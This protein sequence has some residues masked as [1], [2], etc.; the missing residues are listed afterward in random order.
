VARHNR[1]VASAPSAFV[2]VTTGSAEKVK[3][4]FVVRLGDHA[5]CFEAPPPP[6]WFVQVVR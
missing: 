5:L 4:M 6:A 2:E 3:P 1:P